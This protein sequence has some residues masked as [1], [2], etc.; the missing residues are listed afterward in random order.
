MAGGSNFNVAR[1]GHFFNYDRSVA[2]NAGVSRGQI[3][4]LEN[5][6]DRSVTLKDGKF[7]VDRG[8]NLKSGKFCDA[9]SGATKSA[10]SF[11][12]RTRQ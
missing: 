6:N 9:R 11:Q 1:T 4:P 8:C 12:P 7:Q 10:I 5:Q 3:R 2:I